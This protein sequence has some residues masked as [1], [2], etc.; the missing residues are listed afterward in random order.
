VVR[1]RLYLGIFLVA[2]TVYHVWIYLTIEDYAK[3]SFVAHEI[4]LFSVTAS[5]TL[6]VVCRQFWA[7]YLLIAF[8]MW[9]VGATLIFLPGYFDLMGLSP[10]FLFRAVSGPVMHSLIIWALIS[11]PSIRRL[12]SRNYE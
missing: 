2:I 3:Q 11:V 7:R 9:R 12:V 10:A 5:L 4:P 1:G 8:L 6:G